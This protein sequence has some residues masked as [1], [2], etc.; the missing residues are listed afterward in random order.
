MKNCYQE[1]NIM[2]IKFGGLGDFFL[3][4]Q[5]MYSIK[6]FHKKD[7][8]ILLFLS[9]RTRIKFKNVNESFSS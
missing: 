4:F 2:I 8:L 7:K 3:S 1:K 9:N 5:P 6:A